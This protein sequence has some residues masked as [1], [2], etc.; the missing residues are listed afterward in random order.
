VTSDSDSKMQ[1]NSI[2]PEGYI[3]FFSLNGSVGSVWSSETHEGF[4]AQRDG[5]R[6][7]QSEMQSMDLVL[8]FVVLPI[9]T[10]KRSRK[11]NQAPFARKRFRFLGQSCDG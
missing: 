7:Q 10:K 2:W 1:T 3:P 8:A 9:Q 6:C 5:K 11:R 4:A